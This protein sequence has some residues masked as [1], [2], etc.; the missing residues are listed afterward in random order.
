MPESLEG[1]SN[2]AESTRRPRKDAAHPKPSVRLVQPPSP[3]SASA[4]S[5]TRCDDTRAATQAKKPLQNTGLCRNRTRTPNRRRSCRGSAGRACGSNAC[6]GSTLTRAAVPHVGRFSPLRGL[7]GGESRTRIPS[8]VP[9]LPSRRSG[10]ESEGFL[11]PAAPGSIPP[12]LN[13]SR[14]PAEMEAEGVR[15]TN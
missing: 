3:Y 15:G 1:P 12:R 14:R 8:A 10:R 6:R 7:R 5:R 13:E 11:P 4:P 2:H 9:H